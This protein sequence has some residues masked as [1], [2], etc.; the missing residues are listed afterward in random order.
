VGTKVLVTGSQNFS[1]GAR[2]ID[3]FDRDI[4]SAPGLID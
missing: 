3:L 4:L 1:M 2:N